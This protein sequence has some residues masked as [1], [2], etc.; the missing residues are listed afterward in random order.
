MAPFLPRDLGKPEPLS[1][2]P[3]HGGSAARTNGAMVYEE[4]KFSPDASRRNHDGSHDERLT[5]ALTK[6]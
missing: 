4:P 5:Y 1:R 3:T 6:P 2:M